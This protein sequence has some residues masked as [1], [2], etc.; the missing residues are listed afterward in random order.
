[1]DILKSK[2][3]IF[4]LGG[5]EIYQIYKKKTKHA[6]CSQELIMKKKIPL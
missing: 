3:F 1:M 4:S 6:L 2:S 5:G